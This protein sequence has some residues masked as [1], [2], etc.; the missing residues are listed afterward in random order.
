M[1]K[2]SSSVLKLASTIQRIG[3]K[4]RKPTSQAAAVEIA[5]RRLVAMRAMVSGLEIP[6]DDADQEEGDDVGEDDGD[7]ASSGG[8]PDVVLDQGLRIDQKGDVGGLQSRPTARG[9]EDLGK[10]REEEDGLD[11]DD[12]RDRP[13]QMRQRDV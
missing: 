6:S 11:Q 5:T 1:A 13:R 9:D 3:K 2:A 7:Q 8:A 12:H 4:I 10:H